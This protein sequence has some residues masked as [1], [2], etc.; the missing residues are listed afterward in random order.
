MAEI[1]EHQAQ[2]GSLDLQ[3]SGAAYG[4]DLAA[5]A[6]TEEIEHGRPTAVLAWLERAR[7]I[8]ARVP[9]VQPPADPM[10]ADLLGQLRWV[11]N[12]L[13]TG[14]RPRAIDAEDLRRPAEPAAANDPRPLLDIQ[15][16]R[17]VGAIPTAAAIRAELDPACL[18]AI[19]GLHDQLHAVVL[20]RNQSWQR[21]LGTMSDVEQLGMR[22]N[23]DF[24]VLA[25]DLRPAS[26]ARLGAQFAGQGTSGARRDHAGAART[27]QPGRSFCC[28]PGNSP[29]CP[30]VSCRPSRV[31]R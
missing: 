21:R 2:F 17:A 24:D 30:G 1:T 31:G 28:H 7:A 23:A 27:C 12:R 4:V 6:V 29:V 26:P 11:I 18:V 25:M 16:P 9:E 15:G 14:R 5:L 13:E 10:T 3:I 20:T 8:S 19:F 22:V